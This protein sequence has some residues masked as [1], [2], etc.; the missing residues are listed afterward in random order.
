MLKLT[1]PMGKSRATY[2]LTKSLTK[3]E[4]EVAL[5]E[6]NRDSCL[7]KGQI[8]WNSSPDVLMITR[9]SKE[10]DG[11]NVE[12]MRCLKMKAKWLSL[13]LSSGCLQHTKLNSLL[14]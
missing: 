9:P 3:D 2:P 14:C 13:R 8:I 4:Q 10:K 11:Y 1:C 12:G 5:A 6:Q 7:P